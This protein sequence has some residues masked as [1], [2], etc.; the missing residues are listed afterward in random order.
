M[1]KYPEHEKQAKVL[2]Q[3]QTIGS[4]L[5]NGGLGDGVVLAKWDER[6]GRDNLYPIHM[7]INK[8]LAAYF[9]I[10][11]NKIEKEKQQMLKDL[12]TAAA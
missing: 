12:R 3:S 1:R 8:I 10:D 2:D 9:E 11:L 4:F 6:P 7:D 5:D